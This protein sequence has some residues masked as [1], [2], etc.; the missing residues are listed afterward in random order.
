ML[1]PKVVLLEISVAN[2]VIMAE[3]KRKDVVQLSNVVLSVTN[4]L[5]IRSLTIL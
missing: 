2:L 5:L 3:D 4:P 1:L